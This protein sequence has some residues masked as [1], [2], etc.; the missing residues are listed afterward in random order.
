VDPLLNITQAHEISES[1]ETAL[2]EQLTRPVNVMV[3]VEPDLPEL[4]R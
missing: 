2:M 1:L 3:H 4:R